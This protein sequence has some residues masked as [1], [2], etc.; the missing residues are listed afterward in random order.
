MSRIKSNY[1]ESIVD[2]INVANNRKM[3]FKNGSRPQ[4]YNTVRRKLNDFL[5]N[6][7]MYLMSF[8]GKDLDSR[9]S[10]WNLE[11]RLETKLNGTTDQV[12]EILDEHKSKFLE[13]NTECP[14]PIH[15]ECLTHE[16]YMQRFLRI[17]ELKK[18]TLK[19]LG[20]VIK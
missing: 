1:V 18:N 10:L 15:A 3:Q 14:Y 8:Y 17:E 19:K 2:E 20:E 12:V 5:T 7:D 4:D 6:F 16:N 11:Y 9:G 13:I